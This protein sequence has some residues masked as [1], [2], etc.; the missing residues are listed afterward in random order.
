MPTE[1]IAMPVATTQASVQPF[2]AA[3]RAFVERLPE[4]FQRLGWSAEQVSAH[5]TEALR[6]LLRVAVDRSP[7]HRRRLTE[8]AGRIDTFELA[9]LGQLPVMT[10]AE[11]MDEYDDVVT[12]RRLTRACV[13]VFLDGIGETPLALFDEYVV[14]ASGGSSGVRGVFAWS[15]DLVPDYL[16]TILRNGLARAGGGSVPSGLTVAM[17]AASSAVHATRATT[18]I[19]DGT[20]GTITLAPAN[21]PIE[22]IV[23]RLQR[24]QPMLL[25]GYAGALRLVGEQ[26]LAGRLDI[27]P[28]MVVSTSEQLTAQA[29]SVI[30]DAFGS[31][32]GN[33]FGSSEGLNGSALPGDDVFTFASD[34]A[35]VE[36]V[37]EHDRPVPTGTPAHHV[38]VTNLVNTTQPLIRYRL[39]DAMTEHPRLSGSGHQRASVDGRTDE[40]IRF[41]N[42]SVHPIVV[43]S[44]L[45]HYSA[46]VEYQ[47]RT[48][49]NSMH[50]AV[51][52]SGPLDTDR[53]AA[54]LR[55]GLAD[56]GVDG[57]TVDVAEAGQ[58]PRDPRTGKLVRFVAAG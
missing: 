28:V 35:H 17:V 40:V 26:Q 16:A 48:T 33:T 57:V 54:D 4:H 13:D 42:R 14:L 8:I 9:D 22:E 18:F 37:D 20:V 12:D 46:V 30:T 58:L 5:Q 27:H 43:R 3:R 1:E 29:A 36:F 6:R 21:L 55:R 31:P 23:N 34:A 32:P 49:P 10:K 47:V 11:M 50:V 24:A 53:L 52:H 45:L 2:A 39:D 41:G 7:F 15:M 25:A 19:V 38:L 51:V 44:A 56:A